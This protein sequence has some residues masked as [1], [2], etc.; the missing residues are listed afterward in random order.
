M[1]TMSDRGSDLKGGFS[2]R[3][4]SKG[5]GGRGDEANGLSGWLSQRTNGAIR[6]D[7]TLL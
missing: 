2:Q 7:P 4:R 3:K 6:R 1:E 5:Y